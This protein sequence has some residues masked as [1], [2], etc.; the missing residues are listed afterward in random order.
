MQDDKTGHSS[1][2]CEIALTKL[3]PG[4]TGF[5]SATPTPSAIPLETTKKG[6]TFYMGSRGGSNETVGQCFDSLKIW[7]MWIQA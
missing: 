6:H 3:F 4:F 7:V 1:G 2:R 5:N